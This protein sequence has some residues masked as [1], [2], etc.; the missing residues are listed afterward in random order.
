MEGIG[1]QGRET[2]RRK[3]GRIIPG[4]VF[5]GMIIGWIGVQP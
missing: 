2:N 4:F 1:W 3:T 5:K